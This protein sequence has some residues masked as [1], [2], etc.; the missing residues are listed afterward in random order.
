MLYDL[1][2]ERNRLDYEYGRNRQAQE[3]GRFLGQ[4]RF[5]R[6]AEDMTKNFKRSAVPQWAAGAASRGVNSRV[7]SGVA[8]GNLRDRYDQFNRDRARLDEDFAGQEAS[9]ISGRAS[10]DDAYRRALLALSDEMARRRAEQPA[11]GAY[12]GVYG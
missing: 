7:R 1:E 11:F 6:S 3:F 9:F 4:T 10:E 8:L 5:K 2:K 12:T